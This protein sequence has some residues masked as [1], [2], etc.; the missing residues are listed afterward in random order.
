MRKVTY[1]LFHFTYR[2]NIAKMENIN[3]L[4]DFLAKILKM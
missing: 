3:Y 1:V 2:L 4:Y